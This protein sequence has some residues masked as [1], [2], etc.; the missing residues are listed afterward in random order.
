MTVTTADKLSTTAL[1]AISINSP[2]AFLLPALHRLDLLLDCAVRSMQTQQRKE[3]SIPFRGLYIS[4]E[5]VAHALAQT[6]ESMPFGIDRAAFQNSAEEVSGSN[7]PLAGLVRRFGLTNFDA[8]LVILAL[9]SEIDLRYEKI[10]AYLQDDVTRK[11]PTLDLALNVLWSS[12]E[13]KLQRRSCFSMEAP[14]FREGLAC[15]SPD[16]NQ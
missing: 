5:D 7:S 2:L 9:A 4:D 13:E 16:P 3:V 12:V 15:L 6:P 14:L 8:D 10:F 11:R 1:S